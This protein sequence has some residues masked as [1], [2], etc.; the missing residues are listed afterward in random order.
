M[1][2]FIDQHGCA[3]N[4]TDGE[5]IAGFLMERG[6]EFTL[7]ADEAD[8]ILVNSCGFI[9][10]AKKES[11]DAVCNIKQAYPKAKLVLTGCLA[12][13]YAGQL[14]EQMPELD[15]V[16]G[17]GDLSK[18]A[19][20]MDG[21]KKKRGAETFPQ[22]G[23]CGGARPVI[24][25]F[26]GSAFVKITEGCSNH[27]SFCAIPLIRGKLRSRK[28][29]EILREIKQL[30]KDGVYEINLIG[31]DLAAYGTDTKTSLAALLKKIAEIPG[32]FIVRP[33]YI[34]P[35]HFTDDIIEAIKAGSGRLLPYFDIPFQSGDDGIILAMNRTGSFKEYVALVKK[36]R[37]NLPGAVLRTTFLTGFP[38]ESDEAADNTARFLEE[39]QPDWSGCFP[40]S[41][42][43]DTPAWS[44]KGRVPA[45][46]AKARAARLED[47]QTAITADHLTRYVGKELEVLVE[48]IIDAEEEGLAIG[49]AWFQ[50]PEVDG[51][52]VIRYDLD[53]SAAVKDLKP[54]SVVTVKVLASTGV[55]LD[56]RLVKISR[57]KKEKNERKFIF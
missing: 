23:V 4:Q 46:T 8:F 28:E 13:R 32:D 10:S 21:I 11:I 3:K 7:N 49:R 43:E 2:F 35:D 39:I 34:H 45:K 17:N 14:I 6:Y 51:S 16:F 37:R 40:Y 19:D 24:F 33:L 41:R 5:L 30:V 48:E 9:Q 52:V 56:S 50:A 25:N 44:M 36:I 26:P 31:Q 20:F 27:C 42:E 29:T 55:D 38:G 54:G 18:I 53:D 47:L 1:K 22:K 12:E 15:G 57:K